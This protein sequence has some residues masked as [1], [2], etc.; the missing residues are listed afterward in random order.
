MKN[1]TRNILL[2]SLL[3]AAPV[4]L[5]ADTEA[6]FATTRDFGKVIDAKALNAAAGSLTI[7]LTGL[8]KHYSTASIQTDFTWAAASTVVFT[9]SGSMNAGTS[10]APISVLN[11]ISG[12][13][14]ALPAITWTTSSL[15]ANIPL[16]IS[17]I[18]LDNIKCVLS[19]A[20]AGGSDFV[21]SYAAVT[22]GQ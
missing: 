19:G 20:G 18:G 12:A 9:C 22:V 13:L 11:S 1:A 4:A 21:T 5:H 17:A 8:G 6:P 10:Y 3:I 14:S 16:Q 7:T 15:S 2:A